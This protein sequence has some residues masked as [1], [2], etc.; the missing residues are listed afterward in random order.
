MGSRFFSRAELSSLVQSI[1]EQSVHG[2]TAEQAE[3]LATLQIVASSMK[4]VCRSIRARMVGLLDGL[5]DD[6][7]DEEGE[8]EEAMAF[9]KRSLRGTMG[10]AEAT[11]RSAID[12][13]KVECD[14]LRPSSSGDGCVQRAAASLE[15]ANMVSVSVGISPRWSVVPCICTRAGEQ[16]SCAGPS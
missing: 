4:R 2:C 12:S 11:M 6:D 14:G 13:T 16:R 1:R 3:A 7:S 9:V 10:Y 8:V 15:A 5:H